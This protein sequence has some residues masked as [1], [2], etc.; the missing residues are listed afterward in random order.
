MSTADKL[1]TAD[2]SKAVG[3]SQTCSFLFGPQEA[4]QSCS[5]WV[6]MPKKVLLNPY[7]PGPGTPP[8]VLVGRDALLSECAVAIATTHDGVG[9]APLVVLGL[10]GT[11]KTVLLRRVAHDA[12]HQHIF[13]LPIE[14]ES[15]QP[16]GLK[17]RIA[18]QRAL[19][20]FDR[21]GRKAGTLAR[22]VM[23]L[24]PE[25]SVDMAG[26]S[27]S[28]T[29][30]APQA[31]GPRDLASILARLN[32]G[33]RAHGRA[34][35]LLLDEVQE[36]DIAPLRTVIEV[37]H[38][39]LAS[40]QPI[41]LIAAGIPE[42]QAHLRKARTYSVR[43]TYRELP[44]L[45]PAATHRALEEP[46]RTG[47]ARF[48]PEALSLLD[49]ETAGY[50]Y[51]VQM[52]GATVWQKKE[53][54]VINAAAV[55][56]AL[57]IVH[58]HLDSQFYPVFLN[59]LTLRESTYVLALASIG[60]SA[61]ITLVA[62]ALGRTPEGVNTIRNRLIDKGVIYSPSYGQVAP[63]VPLLDRFLARHPELTKT[64]A[65]LRERA[66]TRGRP[67]LGR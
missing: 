41:M 28:L 34:F 27:V 10:R 30:R 49:E 7:R 3:I 33:L 52:Y 42:A 48:T 67:K 44:F 17:L 4:V 32:D 29:P 57:P 50:P 21:V 36:V 5:N 65:Q 56:L 9:V 8:L 55:R 20:H 60:Q 66:T 47:G 39:S 51:F 58:E 1:F 24:L 12:G 62:R 15:G 19:E 25:V 26:A 38:E 45:T 18:L 6:K 43:F 13:A 64:R 61:S 2:L 22:Q 23:E 14:G 40:A 46:A 31:A 16:F 63:A 53:G 11:G 37:V 35:V 54:P 59:R